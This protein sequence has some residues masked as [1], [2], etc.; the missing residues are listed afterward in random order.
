MTRDTTGTTVSTTTQE[1]SVDFSE[2]R[3]IL[4]LLQLN[5]QT[6]MSIQYPI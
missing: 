4:P 3:E 1:M 5:V 6:V 2:G